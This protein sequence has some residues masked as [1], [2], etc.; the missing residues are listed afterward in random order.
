MQN[1]KEP[2]FVL[3]TDDFHRKWKSI[4]YN[5]EKRLVKLLLTES[6][7][8]I[9]S[10]EIEFDQQLDGQYPNSAEEKKVEIVT[11]HQSYRNRLSQKRKKK[12]SKFSTQSKTKISKNL[13]SEQQPNK[14]TERV[15]V[16][17]EISVKDQDQQLLINHN[18]TKLIDSNISRYS[19]KETS[20]GMKDSWITDNRVRRKKKTFA[21]MVVEGNENKKFNSVERNIEP[22][23]NVSFTTEDMVVNPT[24]K[25]KDDNFADI[26]KN[27][28]E[29]K[30][31]SSSQAFLSPPKICPDSS[32]SDNAANSSCCRRNT[33]F[34][35]ISFNTQDSQILGI[36]EELQCSEN[37][38][39]NS[40]ISG[41]ITATSTEQSRLT[42]HFVSNTIFNLSRKVLSEAE[43]KVLEKGLDFAPI[44][45]KINEPE[46]R[47]DFDEFCRRMR[48]KWHFRNQPTQ[49]FSD[50]PAFSAKSTW[51]PPKGYPNIEVLLSQIE[52]EL[53]QI[54]DKCLPYSNLTKE[55]WLAVRS[56]ADNRS[57]V[58]KKA[59]KGSCIVVWD[60]GDYLLEAEKQL[61]DRSVYKDISFN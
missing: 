60:R 21:Q 1:K 51:N 39:N 17:E 61:G 35:E 27:L 46:L 24:V 57:I 54:S 14:S 55:Q 26:Y 10:I 16:Q 47:K 23:K 2:A 29:T 40:L 44:Q 5:T 37:V 8:V 13:T 6:E 41:N 20:T 34:E 22:E 53:F 30:Q 4:L 50:K 25:S 33:F 28:L 58:I 49:D 11:R 38:A 43:I 15:N 59:D 19:S 52:H 18:I 42:G 3:V 9:T 45:D 36:L 31:N 48:I 32:S 7:K 12:W 56:L